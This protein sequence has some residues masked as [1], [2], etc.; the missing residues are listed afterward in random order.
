M[1]VSTTI[2]APEFDRTVSISGGIG[3]DIDTYT[4]IVST[5]DNITDI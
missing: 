2:I 4:C 3:I 1:Y 5:I